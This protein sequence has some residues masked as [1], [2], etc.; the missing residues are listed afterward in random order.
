MKVIKLIGY[1][2]HSLILF[3]IY[4]I[5]NSNSDIFSD[6]FSSSLSY[7]FDYSI[8]LIISPLIP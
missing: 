4:Y 2:T 8:M 5:S 7:S 6:S 1:I 3:N